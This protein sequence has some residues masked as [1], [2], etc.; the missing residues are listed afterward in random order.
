MAQL[1][2]PESASLCPLSCR[3]DKKQEKETGHTNGTSDHLAQLIR[4]WNVEGKAFNS[5][6]EI[7]LVCIR[8]RIIGDPSLAEFINKCSPKQ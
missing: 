7:F 6:T 3:Q 1:I 2:R 4:A 8:R 5:A